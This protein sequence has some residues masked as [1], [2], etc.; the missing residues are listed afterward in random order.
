M[1]DYKP[2]CPW[3]YHGDL[4]ETIEEETIFNPKLEYQCRNCGRFFPRLLAPLLRELEPTEPPRFDWHTREDFNR[5]DSE[6]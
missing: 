5:M 6:P 2:R 4:R 3:C 1:S